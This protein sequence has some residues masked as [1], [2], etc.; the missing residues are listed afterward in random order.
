MRVTYR[1]RVRT[2]MALVALVALGFGATFEWK[3]HAELD[4]LLRLQA[5]RY[6]QAAIHLKRAQECNVPEDSKYPYRPAERAKLLAGDRIRSYPP[7]GF[8]SWQAE[9]AHHLYWGG[10]IYDEADGWD[11]KLDAI[12]A[13]QF[14]PASTGR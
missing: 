11:R 5:D 6:R 12:E 9:R 3:N 7:G 8:L 13:R 1:F 2:L 14:L 4:R 10:R